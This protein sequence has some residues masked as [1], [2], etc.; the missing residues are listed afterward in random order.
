MPGNVLKPFCPACSNRLDI[1]VGNDAKLRYTCPKGCPLTYPDE[2]PQPAMATI[3]GIQIPNE[4]AYVNNCWN[5]ESFVDSRLPHM[6]PRDVNNG[7]NDL[8]CCPNCGES[9]KNYKGTR[10]V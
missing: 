8:F 2:N 1:W 6:C 5:C 9:M 10:P 7:R 4:G 3:F